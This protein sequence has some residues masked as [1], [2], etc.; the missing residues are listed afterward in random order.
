MARLFLIRH[1]EPEAA[2]GG[3]VDDPGLS[4]RGKAQAEAAAEA[5]AARGA[6]A[7]LTSPL[8]RCRETAAPYLAGPGQQVATIAPWFGEVV[9]PLGVADRRAW[10]M[11]NFPWRAGAGARAWSSVDPALR[12]WRDEVVRKAS[13]IDADTAVF[14]HF[15]VSNVLV[16]AAM[17]CAET[18]AFRPDYASITELDVRGGVLHVRRLGIE[19][20]DGEVR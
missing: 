12:D 2:W 17:K 13:A 19:M 10:L 9:T 16:G 18:I 1:G 11:E 8:R 15:I 20:R 5:L 7:V 6:L 4:D 14:T 3:V